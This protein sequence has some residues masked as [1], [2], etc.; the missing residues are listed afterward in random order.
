MPLEDE[1]WEGKI[2]EI[3]A[4]TESATTLS[5]ITCSRAVVGTF[6]GPMHHFRPRRYKVMPTSGR[7]Q[8]I[9]P[10]SSPNDD[11]MSI[12]QV[13]RAALNEKECH[14]IISRSKDPDAPFYA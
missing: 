12:F 14:G 4:T 13:S 7:M 9:D 11:L 1:H 10:M 6:S 3:P 2:I 8:I 5:A